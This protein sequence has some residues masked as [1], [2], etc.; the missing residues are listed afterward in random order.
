MRLTLDIDDDLATMLAAAAQYRGVSIEGLA[1]AY[2][3]DWASIDAD[4]ARG[5]F[6]RRGIYREGPF[7][8]MSSAPKTSKQQI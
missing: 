6:S 8:A 1:L 4:E 5:R 3:R 2:V 7:D